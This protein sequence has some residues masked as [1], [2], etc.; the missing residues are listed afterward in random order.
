MLLNNQEVT[1]EIIE[2]IKNMYWNKWQ[3]KR[4]NSKP[5]GWGKS[6]AK[7]EI[8]SNISLPQEMRKTSNLTLYL[9]QLEKKD[10]KKAQR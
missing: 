9:K 8:Y 4:D 10:I 3:W 7:R 5:M 2:E 1:E 6:T